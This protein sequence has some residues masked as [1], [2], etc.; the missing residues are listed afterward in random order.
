MDRLNVREVVRDVITGLRIDAV[1]APIGF[2]VPIAAI[3]ESLLLLAILPLVWLLRLFSID[4]RERYSKALE[5]QRAYRGTVMLL[6]DVVESDDSYTADHSRSVVE[7]AN[8]VA[9][10]LGFPP[11]SRQE[12]EFAALLHDVG[13]I[14]INKE[15]LNKPAASPTPSSR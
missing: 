15:I 14:A 12:L 4:R 10:E 5:L 3:E 1:L 7:L 9:E 13:K 11:D 8:A 6:S 2:V